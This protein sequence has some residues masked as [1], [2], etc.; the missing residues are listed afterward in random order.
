MRSKQLIKNKKPQITPQKCAELTSATADL[1]E[2]YKEGR[3]HK[4]SLWKR[5]AVSVF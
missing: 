5:A 1:F 4:D 3:T 2:R